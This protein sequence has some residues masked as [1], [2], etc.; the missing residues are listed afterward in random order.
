MESRGHKPK[1]TRVLNKSAAPIQISAEQLMREAWER[2]DQDSVRAPAQKIGDEEELEDNQFRKRATFENQ[3]RAKRHSMSIWLRYAKWE[4][5][6]NEYTRSR[7]VYERALEI[8]YKNAGLYL[9]YA[10]MEMRAKNINHARN[11]YDRAVQLLPRTSAIWYKYIMMEQILHNYIGVRR[12]YE[13]WMEWEPEENAWKAYISFEMRNGELE[14]VRSIYQ[15]YVMCH[16]N[17]QTFIKYARFEE[18]QG[19][20]G[21]ARLVYEKALEVLDLQVEQHTALYIAF[22]EFEVRAK[23]VERARA[24]YKFALDR[25][26]KNMAREIFQ[27]FI[28]FEKQHG[29]KD[30][31][32]SIIVGKRRFQY[33]E[34][35]ADNA[36]YDVWFDYI[37][38]E[39]SFGN[40]DKIREIYERSI[41]SDNMPPVLEK[42]YWK[43]YIYLWINYA[44]FEELQTKDYARAREIY[45]TILKI[46]PHKIFSFNKLWK[47]FAEFEIRRHNLQAARK[48]YGNA[49]GLAPSASLYT[50]YI[51]MEMQLAE[52]DRCRMIFQKWLEFEPGNCNAWK[53]FA[54][55]EA[56]PQIN[57][58]E[59][60]RGILELA[61]SQPVLDMPEIVW[62]AYIDLEIENE[63]VGRA[64]ELY[65]RLLE[66]TKHVRV[67]ISFAK[68]EI[69]NGNIKEARKIYQEAFICLKSPIELQEQRVMLIESWR[70]FEEEHGDEQTQLHV[71]NNMP[72]RI[73]K[74]KKVQND[75]G[76]DSGV[77]VTYEYVFNDQQNAKAGSKLLEAAKKWKEKKG[78]QT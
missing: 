22:A 11:L 48:I 40:K 41:A 24:I 72:T 31:I 51:E 1:S 29:D 36:S 55:L 45:Q 60:A 27:K 6:Q 75:D 14:L 34:L 30:A 13:R 18:K 20:I 38:L 23:E 49:L 43:R 39:E 63:E 77:Q 8:D 47:L 35:L 21:N 64:R 2:Q 37:K 3:V 66:R 74:R 9:K 25:I 46:I 5:S 52:I 32:E 50:W 73:I 56:D 54:E 69:Q 42:Q 33:E 76:S 7:S 26:P 12:I 62:K 61:V 58:I 65:R 28:Q 67:W 10:E 53:K 68:F 71:K 16:Q 15:R 57:E 44:L 4:E 19:E 70:D 78:M 59:R 17:T